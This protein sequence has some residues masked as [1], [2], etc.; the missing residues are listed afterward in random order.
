MGRT[1]TEQVLQQV[2]ARQRGRC[3]RAAVVMRVQHWGNEADG[4]GVTG[5]GCA[6][7]SLAGSA[8]LHEP[9]HRKHQDARRTSEQAGFV[10][11]PEYHG[12]VQRIGITE[13]R[14]WPNV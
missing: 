4:H 7:R 5:N 1:E 6:P 9:A 2:F 11:F 8:A 10:Q 3:G 12:A 13:W 14:Q